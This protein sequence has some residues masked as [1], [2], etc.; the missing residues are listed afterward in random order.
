M[1]GGVWMWSNLIKNLYQAPLNLSLSFTK[2]VFSL[3]DRHMLNR[4]KSQDCKLSY[5]SITIVQKKGYFYKVG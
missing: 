1:S 4:S 5:P 3:Q 2:K